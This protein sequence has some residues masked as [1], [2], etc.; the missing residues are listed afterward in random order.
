VRQRRPSLQRPPGLGIFAC[1]RASED[2]GL[3]YSVWLLAQFARAARQDDFADALREAGMVVPD[4][5]GV[6]DVAASFSDAVDRR[7]CRTH[8]RTDLGEMAQLAAVESLTSLLGE[9]ST[10]LYK[11]TPAEVA[12]AAY[13]LSTTRGFGTLAH[14]FFSRFAH[15]F[16]TYHLGRELSLHV[17]GNG[18]FVDPNEHNHFVERLHVHCQEA[19]GIMSAFASDWYSKAQSPQGKGLTFAS[20]RGF[21]KRSLMKLQEELQIRGARHE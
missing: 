20:T 2:A 16:L 4:A 10:R 15:R 5:P 13:G 1:L 21:V 17:G 12:E 9:R 6:F 8:G 19:S 14:D 18:C 3:A 11:T 7:L